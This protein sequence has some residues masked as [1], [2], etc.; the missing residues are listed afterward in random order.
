VDDVVTTGSTM[1][2]ATRSMG[3]AALPVSA[4]AALAATLRRRPP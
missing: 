4:G 2:E 3:A 1:A